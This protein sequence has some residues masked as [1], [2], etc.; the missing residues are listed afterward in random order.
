MAPDILPNRAEIFYDFFSGKYLIEHDNLEFSQDSFYEHVKEKH[1]RIRMSFVAESVEVYKGMQKI[2]N[3][4]D[5]IFDVKERHLNSRKM[6]F[7]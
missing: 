4:I 1:A 3:S 7:K 5:L 2:A 6:R